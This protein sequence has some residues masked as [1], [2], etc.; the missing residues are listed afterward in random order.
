MFTSWCETAG[1]TFF[2]QNV[3]VYWLAVG[4]YTEA[5]K[6]TQHNLQRVWVIPKELVILFSPRC[7]QWASRHVQNPQQRSITHPN[8]FT[9]DRSTWHCDQVRW[10]RDCLHTLN[11]IIRESGKQAVASVM[12]I[13]YRLTR[14]EKLLYLH[15]WTDTNMKFASPT[16]PC[17]SRDGVTPH[18]VINH[19][20][21]H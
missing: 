7:C 14:L 19:H 6:V 10:W 21:K 17:C 3:S 13:R 12:E 16:L 1:T 4:W 9:H 11:I 8:G 15:Y 18:C 2:R 5:V 20:G